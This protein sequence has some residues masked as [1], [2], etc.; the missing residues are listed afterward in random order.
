[1]NTNVNVNTEYKLLGQGTYGCVY[2]PSFPCDPDIASYKNKL[3]KLMLTKDALKEI[4]EY[5]LIERADR[6]TK[7]YTG[8]PIYCKIKKTPQVE[9]AIK[10][11]NLTRKKT[12]GQ[13][14]N[15]HS[16]LVIGDGGDD[17]EK[18]VKKVVKSKNAQQEIT[19]FWKEMKRLFDGLI[20]FKKYNLV[21]HDLKPQNI[22]F[23]KDT[24]RANFIDFGLMRSIKSE[25]AKCREVASCKGSS[26]WNYPTEVIFMNKKEFNILAKQNVYDRNVIYQQYVNTIVNNEN[27]KFANAFNIMVSYIFKKEND[28]DRIR[29]I[30]KYMS[31]WKDLLMSIQPNKYELFLNETIYGFDTFGFGISLMYILIRVQ[32][33]MN[34]MTV[35]KLKNL[36][37][38]M[39][40][41]NIF[42]R[43]TIE[44]AAIEYE[45]ILADL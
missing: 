20:L 10:K 22:V 35:D 8:N 31:E 25:A 36:F 42:T 16:L 14:I 30:H 45:T 19:D 37:F 2:K 1:M 24:K 11:C 9:R 17:L 15:E 32:P 38:K 6:N 4:E 43:I 23:K 33:F 18:W 29:F 44:D 28:A 34:P 26:H 13:V 12:I 7:Y 41:P 40:T 39:I 21:H 3:S 27:I 5:T